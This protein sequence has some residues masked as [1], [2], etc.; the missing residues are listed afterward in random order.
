MLDRF[1]CYAA[2]QHLFPNGQEVLLAVSGGRDSVAMAHLCRAAGIAFAVAH[3]N[4]HL[5][6]G[7]CDRDQRFVERLARRLEVPFF[8]VGFDTT[9]YASA[10]GQSIEQAARELRYQWFASLCRQHGYAA[11]ATAH[12]ADDAVE[13]FFL[14]LI[15]GTGIAG[16]HGIRPVSTMH[17]PDGDLSVVRPMLCFSRADIDS[18]VRLNG[19]EYVDDS[20]NLV[21]EV[22]RNRLRL[23][24]LP[25][26]RQIAPAFDTVMQGNIAR[27]S[28]VE[29]VYTAHLSQLRSRLVVP[30]PSRVPGVEQAFVAISL[31]DIDCLSPQ[32][33]L[34]FELLRPYGFTAD[35]VDELLRAP[36]RQGALF[37]SPTHE[38]TVHS[39]L[40]VIGPK[41]GEEAPLR[42]S[43]VVLDGVPASLR[44]PP[45]EILVDADLLHGQLSLRPWADGDRFHP[46]GMKG[47]RLV[48]DFLKDMRLHRLEK[49]HVQL[50]CDAAGTPV[51]VVGL[52]A[53]ARFAVGPST[54]RVMR[55]SLL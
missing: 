8:S 36:R 4:F 14:N 23:Q 43:C 5:R 48:S 53:D 37:L 15:R 2:G 29:Q 54:R 9:A 11:V 10:H 50:L 16:L 55:I 22:Q 26:L 13:T 27:L 41:G 47:S 51:W 21:P 3:C 42:Y 39:G 6:P 45:T 24:V 46:F 40:L 52:R 25:L 12:H 34:L 19:I 18:Y 38:A 20:T 28:E 1:Q 49:R 32:R 30:Q 7:E 17:L 33:T 31:S 44:T 35:V